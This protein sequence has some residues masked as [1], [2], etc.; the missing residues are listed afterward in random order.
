MTLITQTQDWAPR[1]LHNLHSVCRGSWH[2]SLTDIVL[3]QFSEVKTCVGGGCSNDSRLGKCHLS[4]KYLLRR[5]KYFCNS[6]KVHQWWW[7]PM[8]GLHLW[9]RNDCFADKGKP[10]M[11]NHLKYDTSLQD[12]HTYFWKHCC[13]NLQ[14]HIYVFLLNGASSVWFE[15]KATFFL[16]FFSFPIPASKNIY[17]SSATLI[18][19]T[20]PKMKPQH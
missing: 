16:L 3:S 17:F 2:S 10:G 12:R 1:L 5:C 15:I 9:I 19:H 20:G 14:M 4:T 11:R 18:N 6:A 7:C 13:W 8:A